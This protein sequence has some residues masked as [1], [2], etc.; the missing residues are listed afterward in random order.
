[1]SRP[2][3]YLTF[4]V[5][6]K[7][8]A[9]GVT[10][11]STWWSLLCQPGSW[12]TDKGTVT[13]F[14]CTW[15]TRGK[16]PFVVLCHGDLKVVMTEAWPSLWWWHQEICSFGEYSTPSQINLSKSQ[17]DT[18]NCHVVHPTYMKR[19]W[20]RITRFSYIGWEVKCLFT[21][22]Y[23]GKL[24]WTTEQKGWENL[25]PCMICDR[26]SYNKFW[27]TASWYNHLDVTS[28]GW[29]FPYYDQKGWVIRFANY[30][31]NHRV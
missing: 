13:Y 8:I 1:M 15:S 2:G 4:R 25:N 11:N 31:V 14:L 9:S 22:C 30:L 3:I 10:P 29:G 16:Y 28:V 23:E 21:F 26:I 24:R 19:K 17:V 20:I 5:L 27:A 18:E 12:V 7:S 6:R